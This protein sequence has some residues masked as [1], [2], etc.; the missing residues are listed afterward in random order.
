MAR[1]WILWLASWKLLFE[2]ALNLSRIVY[3]QETTKDM[4]TGNQFTAK[5][6]H[7]GAIEIAKGLY[8]V[9]VSRSTNKDERL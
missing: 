6:L 7:N 8:V 1:V 5:G 3:A 9:N 4:E 2:V